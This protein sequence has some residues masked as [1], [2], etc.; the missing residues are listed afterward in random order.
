MQGVFDF[1]RDFP[2]R[3]VRPERLFF[4]AFPDAE[5]CERV[6]RFRQLFFDENDLNGNPL[7]LARLHVSLRLIGDFKRLRT[8][9]IYAATLTAMTV[10][11]PPFEVTFR[12]IKSFEE[13]PPIGGR[14]RGRPLVLLGEGD[15]LF[16]LHSALGGAMA[17]NGLR[18][19]AC[20]TPHMTLSYDLKAI[21]EQAIEPIRMMVTEF[22]LVHSELWLTKYN[23]LDRWPLA[24]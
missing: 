11:M 20:F 3:P 21:A 12:A 8:K 5:T 13:G 2:H 17:K 24:G 7:Q 19:E 1:Y 18:S 22:V 14:R 4:G 15:A 10:A 9:I 23:V 6:S 16:K